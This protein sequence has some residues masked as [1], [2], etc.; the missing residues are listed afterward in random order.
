MDANY[1]IRTDNIP[2]FLDHRKNQYKFFSLSL[3][4]SQSSSFVSM[5]SSLRWSFCWSSLAFFWY[6]WLENSR[7]LRIVI[8]FPRTGEMERRKFIASMKSL[9]SASSGVFGL[10]SIYRELVAIVSECCS[11]MMCRVF[12]MH[13]YQCGFRYLWC[14]LMGK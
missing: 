9:L 5:S 14:P 4:V 12:R 3:L 13:R 2:L 8:E 11:V 1:I 7:S 6:S 10:S